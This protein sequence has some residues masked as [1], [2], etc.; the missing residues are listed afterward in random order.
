MYITITPQKLGKNYSQSSADFVGYLEKENQGLEQGALPAGKAGMEHFFNQ[1]D[2]EISADEIVKEIDGNGAKLKKTEPKFYSITVS[3]SNHELNRLQ[4][5]SEDLKRYTREL[6]KDYVASFNREIN[7]RQVSIDDIKYYAK[8]EHQRC[9][10]GT[11]WQI[12][13]NQSFATKILQIKTEIR[14][15]KEGR[16]EGNIKLLQNKID[17]LEK[18]APQQQDGQRIVQGMPKAGNQSHIH[19]IVSR[20]DCLLYTS[21]SPRDRQKTRMPSSA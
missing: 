11:D 15:I 19:I 10:K 21:P 20:K 4:N 6:M 9:F 16:T 13:E 5:S 2:D 12:R 3:P 18:K 17:R 7:G 8:I 14:K 1:Y